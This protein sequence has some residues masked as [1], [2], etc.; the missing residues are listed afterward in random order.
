MGKQKGKS[1]AVLEESD[2]EEV[3]K[4]FGRIAGNYEKTNDIISFGT[5]RLWMKKLV[6]LVH[7]QQMGQSQSI[8]DLCAGSGAVSRALLKRG[9]KIKDLTLI[10]FC[11]EMLELAQRSVH[12]PHTKLEFIN[13]DVCTIPLESKYADQITMAYGLRNIPDRKQALAEMFRLLKPQGHCW[14][15][16]LTR[17]K[18]KLLHTLHQIY[19][20]SLLPAL[21]RLCSQ[22]SDAYR[23]LS[24]SVHN[25]VN[26]EIVLDEM[27][28]CG[29]TF[30]KA[31]PIHLGM[32]HIFHGRKESE[33]TK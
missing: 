22:D 1:I 21:G 17:P 29:F 4:M 8:L 20:N 24:S 25:F 33:K 7:S 27:K 14:I 23:Y 10:D 9:L 15:L 16:E 2:K 11:P 13:A 30:T 6:Q 26:P 18:Q 28:Q 31:I 19:L 12:A 32:V 3:R 5:H